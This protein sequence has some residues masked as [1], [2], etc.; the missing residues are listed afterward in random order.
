[1]NPYPL[2]RIFMALLM[3]V[4]T[5]AEEISPLLKRSAEHDYEAPEPGSYQLPTIKQAAGGPVLDSSGKRLDLAELTRGQITVLS[6]IY[7]RCGDARAC[8]HATGILNELHRLS[9][10][11][12]ALADGMRL[13]SMS[14]DPQ[15]DT[16]E[17][18]AAYAKLTEGRKPGASWH[19]L[20]TGS[21]ADLQPILEGY[22]QSVSRKADPASPTGPLNH[23]LRVLLIDRKGTVR[24]IYSSGTLDLRLVLADLRT[25]LM[26][27]K[28]KAP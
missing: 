16:P 7:S 25:L 20:T 15:H 6:F 26:E 9:T 19:F 21:E 12:P 5:R 23:N 27:P 28:E 2:V 8:P 24:N 10:G 14:F 11:D 4:A 13:V 22:G 18:M 3:L 1:M 17:R